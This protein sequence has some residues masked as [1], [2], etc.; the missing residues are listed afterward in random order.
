VLLAC[1]AQEQHSLP[2]EALAA[3]LA[4]RGERSRMLGAQVPGAALESAIARTGPRAVVLW[5]HAPATADVAQLRA[6]SALR[7]RPA[8]V[9]AA[10]PG[11][12]REELPPGVRALTDFGAA[13][14]LLVTVTRP[15]GVAA[16]G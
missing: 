7:P 13:V 11:W 4:A 8:L 14:D 12:S 3:S 15:A 1:T 10:G 6:V 2:L 16:G 9:A 5:A